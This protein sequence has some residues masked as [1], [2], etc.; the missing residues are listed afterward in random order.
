[1]HIFT[2]NNSKVLIVDSK[3]FS[4]EK[5][6]ISAKLSSQEIKQ[7]VFFK[8]KSKEKNQEESQEE[9]QHLRF[10]YIYENDFCYI[11]II[12]QN[13]LQNLQE[14]Y[15]KAIITT[16]ISF[17]KSLNLGSSWLI[18]TSLENKLIV[19]I[20]T[21]NNFKSY[22]APLSFDTIK[23]KENITEYII[24]FIKKITKAILETSSID[25]ISL[26]IYLD[27]D[28]EVFKNM[29]N[30]I[31]IYQSL[32][33]QKLDKSTFKAKNLDAS[34]S[35]IKKFRL[36]FLSF[37]F[38]FLSLSMLVSNF[39]LQEKNEQLFV[40]LKQNT[41]KNKKTI[42]TIKSHTE[43][44]KD[45]HNNIENI[46]NLS[47]KRIKGINISTKMDNIFNKIYQ[48]KNKIKQVHLKEN[49]LYVD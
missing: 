37:L 41:Q 46:K 30:D 1:M 8:I 11:W 23:A 9:K 39:Y 26:D 22:I 47:N 27:S 31:I 15:P 3:Q 29:K 44:I 38:V 33:L 18:F 7:Y 21:N 12:K 40:S 19:N 25:N 10:C 35:T 28:L 2:I 45:K 36:Y 4:L 14:K 6:K 24:D 20:N 42:H 48:E 49:K 13:I 16:Y 43:Q 34:F 5:E 17:Y 32:P